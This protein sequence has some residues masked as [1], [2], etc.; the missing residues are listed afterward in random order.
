GCAPFNPFDPNAD[1]S[2]ALKF[3]TTDSHTLGVIT[4]SVLNGYVSAEV[5]ALEDLGFAHPLSVVLGGEYRKETSK[6]VPDAWTQAGYL[7]LSG[8]SPVQGGFNVAE[9]FAEASLPILEGLRF[10]DELSIEGAVRLS[11]YSTAGDS[12]SWKY[13]GVYSPIAGL[14]FRAT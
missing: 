2:A 13:G 3:M 5:P 11:H 14:K 6:A 12:T 9:T 4:Q 1:N 7:W 8:S 10:A